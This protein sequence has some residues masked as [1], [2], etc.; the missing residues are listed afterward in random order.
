MA[1]A[2]VMENH[3]I[4]RRVARERESD[5]CGDWDA[6]L[7]WSGAVSFLSDDQPDVNASRIMSKGMIRLRLLSRATQTR[8]VKQAQ[9]KVT[10]PIYTFTLKEYKSELGAG[11]NR[12]SSNFPQQIVGE[13]AQLLASLFLS[14]W[15]YISRHFLALHL[16][17][18]RN[19]MDPERP[20]TE[21]SK[22]VPNAHALPSKAS[23]CL[24]PL[25]TYS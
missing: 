15:P 1:A 13:K 8:Q 3:L 4:P 6:F 16:I 24:L 25:K 17:T 18:R 7:S 20:C 5:S 10:A 9:I 23:L 22:R 14:C 2:T 11:C 21:R 12:Y 19:G